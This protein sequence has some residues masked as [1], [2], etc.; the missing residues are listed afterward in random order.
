MPLTSK[1]C[2]GSFSVVL[3]TKVKLFDFNM[4]FL[5]QKKKKHQVST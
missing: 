3:L 4:F 1:M 5:K 2:S